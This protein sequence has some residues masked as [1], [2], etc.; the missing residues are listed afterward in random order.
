MAVFCELVVAHALPAIRSA[1]AIELVKGKGAT[2]LYACEL[3][4]ITQP[5][6]SQYLKGKRGK[7]VAKI[8]ANKKVGAAIKKLADK[9]VKS[10]NP[11]KDLNDGICSICKIMRQQKMLDDSHYPYR[12]CIK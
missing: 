10:K 7:S 11:H 3:L 6:I 8:T 12:Y 9:L 4:D 2:Q 5:A 1:L